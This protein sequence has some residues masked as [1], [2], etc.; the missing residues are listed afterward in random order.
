MVQNVW[1][2]ERRREEI[3]H[4]WNVHAA[5]GNRNDETRSSKLVGWG[6]HLFRSNKPAT[7]NNGAGLDTRLYE[8]WEARGL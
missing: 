6:E 4:N 7:T 5:V 3:A 8:V 1:Q 2:L